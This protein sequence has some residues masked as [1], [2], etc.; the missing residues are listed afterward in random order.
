MQ[1]VGISFECTPLRSIQRWDIPLDAS[2]EFRERCQCIHR[3]FDVHGAHNS[4]YL[5]DGRCEYYLTND[6]SV[7]T[8]AFRFEGTVLTDA[9]DAKTQMAQLY[10][11]LESETCDWLNPA[12]I[13]WYRET[14]ARAVKIEFDRYI[15]S[16]DP[17]RARLRLESIQEQCNAQ[18]GFVAM[19]L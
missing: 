16:R 10:V 17:D 3:A 1:H 18:G 7:G 11:A 6:A 2:P 14:V 19:G 8:L 9:G 13:T 4:Y 12:V 5:Y 15:A